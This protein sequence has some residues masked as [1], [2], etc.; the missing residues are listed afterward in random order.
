MQRPTYVDGYATDTSVVRTSVGQ[1][2]YARR[3][4]ILALSV[5]LVLVGCVASIVFGSSDISLGT[6]FN[7]LFGYDGSPQEAV[8]RTTRLPRVLIAASVG[9]SL[10]VA[11]CIMQV[12]TRN[13]LAS[14]SILGVNAG[15]SL[16]VV[17]AIFIFKAASVGEFIWF[18]FAGAALTAVA[19]YLVASLGNGGMTAIKVTIVGAALGL[20]CTSMTQGLLVINQRAY[21]EVLFW[22]A[23]SVQGRGFDVF[24]AVVPFVIVG[25][26]V[27]FAIARQLTIMSLG[28]DVAR[29][30]GQKTGHFKIIAAVGVVLLA[31]GSVAMAGPIGFVGLAVPHVT[32]KLVGTDYRWIIPEAAL[33]GAALLLL[34]DTAARFVIWPQE[35]P[36]GV[37]TAVIGAPFLIYLARR[38]AAA[39]RAA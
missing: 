8:V 31:G 38:M 35:L 24:T 25:L 21:Q 4:L 37:M 12:L 32:R 34:A 27:S 19:V 9:A 26:L 15:A 39:G 11:G 5:V 1:R 30:L 14:P 2:L 33:L 10:A 29:G 18:A 23:G 6:I 28:D 22:L 7:A 16:L 13:P 3:R 36:V 17:L 20:F